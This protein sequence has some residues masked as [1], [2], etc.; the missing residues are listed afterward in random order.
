MIP[1]TE[2]DFNNFTDN[3]FD[4]YNRP[5]YLIQRDEFYIFQ[6]FDDNEKTS[7]YNR[8]KFKLDNENLIP[9]KNYIIKKYGKDIEVETKD[10]SLEVK[11]KKEKYDFKSI[12]DYYEKRDDNFI[13]GIVDK[14][15]LDKNLEDIFKIRPPIKKSDKKRGTGIYSL[16]GSVCATSKKKNYLLDKLKRIVNISSEFKISS[17]LS[18]RSDICNEM[19]KFL[20]YL[21]KYGTSSKNN[22]LNYIVIP[23]NHKKYPFPFNLED[24]VKD[25]LGK[26]KNI[27]KREFN[28]QVKKGKNGTF[29][30][31]NLK[32]QISYTIE[33]KNDK[34]LLENKNEINK[35][36]FELKGNNWI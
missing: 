29:D 33:I 14:N 4:K 32:N 10:N 2:N 36:G 1:K 17:K 20:L 6:P 35:L 9:I 24:R 31:L 21:E 19:M 27:M 5:G 12:K 16:T 15:N 34:Y 3:I 7:L 30:K 11:V 22:K 25:K 13:V 23:A 8:T 18:T 28:H 26:V